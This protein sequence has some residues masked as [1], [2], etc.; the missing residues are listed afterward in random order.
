MSKETKRE[1]RE[2]QARDAERQR[3][4][5]IE[6]R[7]VS[8][9]FRLTDDKILSLKEFV[10]RKLSGK[11]K[12][13]EFWALKHA[14]FDVYKGEVMGIIGH[15]GA[16]KST[17]LKVISGILKPTEGTV[18]SH[19]NIVPMLELGSGFDMDLTGHEHIFCSPSTMRSWPSPSWGSL[20]RCPFATIPPVCWP[21]WP[22]P[23]PRW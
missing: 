15:N 10:T 8:M 3:K 14:S 1:L 21:G 5:M 13:N 7:D 6:V 23:S 2:R 17:I 19:G 12:T 20:S 9:R 16:G 4:K 11:L 18:T 22:S